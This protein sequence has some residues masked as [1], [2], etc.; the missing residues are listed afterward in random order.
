[1]N[2][3]G[4]KDYTITPEIF[5]GLIP[6]TSAIEISDMF[7]NKLSVSD[8]QGR[9]RIDGK[10]VNKST[11]EIVYNQ[12]KEIE[13]TSVNILKGTSLIYFPPNEQIP[14]M[15]GD[16]QL[17]DEI[18]GELM[19]EEGDPYWGVPELPTTYEELLNNLMLAIQL[20]GGN[21]TNVYDATFEE[22]FVQIQHIVDNLISVQ[23][24]N[25][26]GTFNDLYTAVVGN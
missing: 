14:I 2:E 25:G 15:D 11:I 21:Y 24:T 19:F 7:L 4:H 17:I 12:I 20:D 13:T 3:L 6:S 8:V 16:V 1:M 22:L 26:N 23:I 9:L 5:T 18:T 10:K